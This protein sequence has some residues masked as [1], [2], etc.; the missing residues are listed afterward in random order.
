MKKIVNYKLILILFLIVVT[1]GVFAPIKVKALNNE[2]FKPDRFDKADGYD[3]L[4]NLN[5]VK[6]CRW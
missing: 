5:V 3:D 2:Y 4:E 6:R 1:V